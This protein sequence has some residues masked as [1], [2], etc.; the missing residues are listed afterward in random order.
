[1]SG[2]A[3]LSDPVSPEDGLVR[4]GEQEGFYRRLGDK[5]SA[6]FSQR[7]DTLV[8]TFENLD[9]VFDQTAD[10]LPWGYAFTKSKNWSLLG[11]MAHEWSWYRDDA[12]LKFFQELAASGFFDQFKRVIFYGASMGA[13]AACAFSSAVPGADVVAISPQATLDRE[14][15]SWE[16]RYHKAWRRDFSGPFGYAPDEVATARR[17]VLF[18]DPAAPLDA[19]HAALFRGDNIQKI[20]CR[21]MGHRIMS[22]WVAMGVLKPVVE[23]VMQDDIDVVALYR[24]M[25]AR[26]DTPRYQKEML[27]RLQKAGRDAL[28][29]RWCEAVLSRRRGPKFRAALR[30]AQRRIARKTSK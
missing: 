16:T 23:E 19:M 5:H 10:R 27:E 20:R 11:L 30:D 14:I 15:A 22:L 21:H 1:M 18:Y 12:V 24:L 3:A 28:V 8:V 7:G 25:R 17:V 2:S 29:V 13:Y 4:L 6:L 26:H 9:H